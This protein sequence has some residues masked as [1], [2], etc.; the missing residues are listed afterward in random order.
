MLNVIE[1]EILN[2]KSNGDDLI[3]RL[4][5]IPTDMPFECK[6]LQF[7]VR[8]AF[9]MTINKSQG[10]SLHVCRLHLENPRFAYGQLYVCMFASGKSHKII[11]LCTR[12][13][14]KKI[15]CMP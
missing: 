4:P 5:V 3:P 8:L 10:Q 14:K 7:H 15:S 6:R 11:H 1:A 9:S 13:K 2:G 12:R